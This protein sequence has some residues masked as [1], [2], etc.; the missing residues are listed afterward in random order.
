M[1]LIIVPF[2]EVEVNARFRYQGFEYMKGENDLAFKTQDSDH[3]DP[4]VF[5]G[6]E[7]CSTMVDPKTG[8]KSL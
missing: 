5:I 7:L 2:R 8:K 1:S 3:P 6:N 4:E